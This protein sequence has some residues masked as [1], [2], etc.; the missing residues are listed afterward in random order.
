[1]DPVFVEESNNLARVEA[2]ID[3]VISE[4]EK[5]ASSLQR[6]TDDAPRYDYKDIS[7]WRGIKIDL[8]KE[9]DLIQQYMSY[10]PSPYFG[11]MDF[12]I[13]DDDEGGDE[14][15]LVGE[16]DIF[17]GH[18]KL[19]YDWRSEQGSFFR[20]KT[21]R[22]F[23]PNDIAKWQ[24][25][26]R[27]R[28]VIEKARL[29][30]YIPEYDNSELTLSGEVVDPF[31][32]EVLRDKRR[33]YRLTDIIRSIQEN[34]NSIIMR[35]PKESFV[36]QGCA[37]SGKTMIL[38]HRLSY[39]LYNYQTLDY[40][41]MKVITPNRFFSVFI[42]ELSHQLELDS[43]SRFT[44]EEY[45][46]ELI[47]RFSTRIDVSSDVISE[48]ALNEELLRSVYSFDFQDRLVE[49]F[50]SFWDN[51]IEQ[52]K[53]FGIQAIF[54]K[55]GKA[56]PDLSVRKSS[57]YISLRSTISDIQ[58]DLE[59]RKGEQ[60]KNETRLASVMSQLEEEEA[61]IKRIKDQIGAARETAVAALQKELTDCEALIADHRTKYNSLNSERKEAAQEVEQLNVRCD[62]LKKLLR[63]LSTERTPTMEE[64]KAL[65]ADTAD[66][67]RTRMQELRGKIEETSAAIEVV[68][69]YNFGRRNTLK[70]QLE[71]LRSEYMQRLSQVISD[72]RTDLQQQISEIEQT[73]AE[74]PKRLEQ[75]KIRMD[76]L[77]SEGKDANFR[78][79][80]AEHALACF[81][82][83]EEFVNV[84]AQLS[85]IE[86][87]AIAPLIHRYLDL[88][89]SYSAAKRQVNSLEKSALS[90]KEALEKVALPVSEQETNNLEESIA[91]VEQLQFS[92]ISRNVL[93][94]TLQ[95]EY[96]FYGQAYKRFNYRHK[97]YLRLFLC[98][99]YYSQRN[100][101]DNF[102]NIDE[103]QDI[104]PAEYQLLHKILGDSCVFNL[105][106]DVN[107]LVYSYKGVTGWEEIEDIIGKKIYILNENYRNTTEVTEF[108][109]QV[110]DADILPI[111]IHGKQVQQLGL[112]E[113]V[114]EALTY[115]RQLSNY[116]VAILY[117][118]GRERILERLRCILPPQE[119]SWDA[120]DDTKISV[121]SIEAAKGL[122]FEGVVVIT[123]SMNLN[124]KYIAFTRSLDYLCVVRDQ[125]PAEEEKAE[126]DDEIE[127]E[128]EIP[129]STEFKR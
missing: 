108:C 15:I 78:K 66:L 118:Y 36:V 1:M 112:L 92:N 10:K 79:K 67:I 82:S 113:A 71:N 9:N 46:V 26:L 33:Q 53:H 91:I 85:R 34:Q 60:K 115:K 58:R 22:V 25:T 18:T 29:I 56:Y 50:N 89:S 3:A 41:R 55:C 81:D 4:H 77:V 11:R 8:D 103:A 23:S 16:H 37:G 83:D 72:V 27:R 65:D 62:L 104:S 127:L 70:G 64:V 99:L 69:S 95:A 74:A 63:L 54:K 32:L 90:C 17:D 2:R 84:S 30:K 45:Y 94:R 114:Q 97:L 100:I 47:H 93:F 123:D 120:V 68:P 86:F 87:T 12:Y 28:L 5:R 7:S 39:L 31:L 107:Q 38:L 125:F 126:A 44:V 122:E 42:D 96:R 14:T 24:L 128:T 111:G 49:R 109:N 75:Y 106:G 129:E 19:V 116:R 52:L 43:I 73:I 88:A 117:R 124:E 61:T 51:I 80:A 105:Y 35:P 102:L 119:V 76:S 101:T 121:L 21:E 98:C 110:F 40:S 59:W 48:K 6:A 13:E 20:R 57:S